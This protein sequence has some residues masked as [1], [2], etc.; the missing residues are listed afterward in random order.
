MSNLSNFLGRATVFREKYSHEEFGD[1][2]I[3]IL[4]QIVSAVFKYGG[5]DLP[6][7]QIHFADGERPYESFNLQTLSKEILDDL[8]INSANFNVSSKM[9][10]VK[11]YNGSPS[12][13]YI[14]I[15]LIKKQ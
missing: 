9:I 14:Y 11:N 5:D 4:G 3:C 10:K 8:S 1:I 13:H 2:K 6:N 15:E 7:F 12:S